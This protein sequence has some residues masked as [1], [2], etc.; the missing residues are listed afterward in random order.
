MARKRG[1]L[2]GIWDRNKQIIK[3]LVSTAAGFLGSPALGAAVGAA[4]GGLDRPG[5]SGIGFDVKQGAIG[6]L[7]GYGAGQL[8]AGIGKMAGYTGP[9]TG[10][11][12]ADRAI[13]NL[14][15]KVKSLFTGGAGGATPVPTGVPGG[16]GPTAGGNVFQRLLTPEVAG[17]VAKG[18]IE[19]IGAQSGLAEEQRQ[20]EKTFGLKERETLLQEQR[21][22]EEKRIQQMDEQRRKNAARILSLLAPRQPATA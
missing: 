18:I 11:I 19:N 3:P 7:Q 15:G 21:L 1:G 6:G 12:G 4:M 2:A 9:L 5:K 10:K 13:S 16:T 17:G 22:A 8:G 14:T 20:F